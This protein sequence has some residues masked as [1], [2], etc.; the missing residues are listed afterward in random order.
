MPPGACSTPCLCWWDT[1]WKVCGV[2]WNA[3]T[4]AISWPQMRHFS[5]SA[6]ISKGV[7]VALWSFRPVLSSLIC[8][9]PAF[10]TWLETERVSDGLG[11][12]TGLREETFGCGPCRCFSGY[13]WCLWFWALVLRLLHGCMVHTYETR[14]LQ[15]SM[16]RL[17]SQSD[18]YSIHC[19]PCF[20]RHFGGYGT[21]TNSSPWMSD[22]PGT[23]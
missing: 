7:L 22:V 2:V 23:W 10:P 12:G 3:T 17:C 19:P 8:N 16:S 14:G 4:S 18:H 6:F 11:Y 5:R 1:G 9:Q 20:T 13:W 21:V 15:P